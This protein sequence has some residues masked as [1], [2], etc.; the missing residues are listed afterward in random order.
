MILRPERETPCPLP[1]EIRVSAAVFVQVARA[2]SFITHRVWHTS[3][4]KLNK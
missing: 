3:N 4:D 2:I 1:I